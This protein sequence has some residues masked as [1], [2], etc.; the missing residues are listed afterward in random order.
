MVSVCDNQSDPTNSPSPAGGGFGPLG[1][2]PKNSFGL[3]LL[4][5]CALALVMAIPALFVFG[6][7]YDRSSRADDAT[8]DVMEIYGGEQTAMGPIILLPYTELVTTDD[9][10]TVRK[11]GEV[12]LYPETGS[13]LANVSTEVKKSGIHEIPVYSAVLEFEA[14]FLTDRLKDALPLNA[15]P[16]WRN[17]RLV[18]SISDSRA[19]REATTIALSGTP[20]TIEP[21]STQRRGINNRYNQSSVTRLSGKIPDAENISG[22]MNVT[23][24]M[25][26]SGASRIALSPFARSTDIQLKSDWNDPKFE[27][28][29]QRK[30]YTPTEGEGFSAE[31]SVPY[32]A[33][34]IP[35][36]GYNLDVQQVIAS[37]NTI[38]VRFVDNATPYQSVQRALKYAI[39]FIGFVF[40]AYFLFEVTSR[41]KAH[42][43]QYVLVGLAQ[44]VFYLLLLALAEQFGF[45][46]A[47]FVAALMTVGMTSAYAMTV[48]KSQ[49]YGLRALGIFTSVY[50]LMYMLM[51]LEDYALLVGAFASFAAIGFTMYMTRH[52]NWYN[53]YESEDR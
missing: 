27:G 49:A 52:I 40:L 47:F 6:V 2:L 36:V 51:R 16:D 25:A 24:R 21:E 18:V 30:S 14:S 19:V 10:V 3:K 42:P 31:W 20:L 7:V 33:R 4:L 37:S 50:A 41:Q 32:E 8:Q 12:V 28:G 13:V 46:L 5:V 15:T 44:A 23:A 38:A 11:E 1:S 53:M 34:G 29:F 26:F 17:A 43:A 22:P 45:D 35:G 39:M 48:F 9:K